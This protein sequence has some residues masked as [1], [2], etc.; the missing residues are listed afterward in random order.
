[1]AQRAIATAGIERIGTY[2]INLSSAY[3]EVLDKFDA[4]QSVDEYG[5][6]IAI[7]PRIIVSDADVKKKREARAQL[8]QQ[9]Q[10]LEM[11]TQAAAAAK[12][13]SESSLEGD[14]LLSRTINNLPNQPGASNQ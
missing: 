8:Q 5:A 9:A 11:A 4:D 12:D 6:V 2:V 7:P 14:N 3:P 13:A 1:M 10:R